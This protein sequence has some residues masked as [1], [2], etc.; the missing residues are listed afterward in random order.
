MKIHKTVKTSMSL[1]RILLALCTQIR[2]AFDYLFPGLFMI[3]IFFLK[4]K[5]QHRTE[6]ILK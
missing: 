6:T 4:I 1:F 5:K 2:L 3:E